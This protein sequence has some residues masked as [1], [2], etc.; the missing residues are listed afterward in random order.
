VWRDAI[1]I[2]H[3]DHGSRIMQRSVRAAY[4]DRLTRQDF[5]DAF[6][7]LFAVR[8]AHLK[9]GVEREQRPLQ[10]LLAEALGLPMERL[11]ANVYLA[12]PEGRPLTPRSLAK[13]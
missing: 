7:T 8:S 11:P 2:I 1:V 9:P 10:E 4:A 12:G 3:G 13:F 5:N 6:S